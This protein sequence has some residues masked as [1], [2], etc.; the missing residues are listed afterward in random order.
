MLPTGIIA[1]IL[2]LTI[3]FTALPTVRR[4][5]YNFF[6]YTHI[7]IAPL[8]IIGVS[9]HASLGFY[10]LF[11]GLLLW[12]IDLGWRFFAGESG[13]CKTVSATISSAGGGRYR[14]ALPLPASA[15]PARGGDEEKVTPAHPLQ[16]YYINI[17]LISRAQKHCNWRN[18]SSCRACALSAATCVLSA[19]A[20]RK[21]VAWMSRVYWK[22]LWRRRTCAMR[23]AADMLGC[24]LQVRTD[25]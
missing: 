24:T 14:I 20:A 16:T 23:R 1:F 8:I 17:P 6:Y 10:F 9:F 11:P 12:T 15:S 18:G 22:R 7:L 21:G 5:A 25:C 4:Q 3:A 13:L 2:L 19:T